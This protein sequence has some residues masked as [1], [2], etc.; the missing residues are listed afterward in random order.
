MKRQ[1]IIDFIK[2][3]FNVDGEH[4]WMTFPDYMVFRNPAGGKWFAVLM[5]VG[6][7]KLGL[8]GEGREDILNVKCDPVLIGSLIKDRSS[9]LPGYHMNKNSWLTVLLGGNAGENEIKD[10]IALSRELTEKK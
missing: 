4:L 6:R 2:E 7:D 9:Y 8:D 10:L 5:D 3:E 1:S